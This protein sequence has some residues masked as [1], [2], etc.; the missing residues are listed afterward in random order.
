MTAAI[1]LQTELIRL[2]AVLLQHATFQQL[3]RI[4]W[5]QFYWTGS[6]L[7]ITGHFPTVNVVSF[8]PKGS[9]ENVN[10]RLSPT[11]LVL[12][13]SRLYKSFKTWTR[14][15]GYFRLN[16]ARSFE[17]KTDVIYFKQH[18]AIK[19]ARLTVVIS[20]CGEHMLSLLHLLPLSR[21]V[22]MLKASLWV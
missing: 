5:S 15:A 20:I 17:T 11:L 1:R 19:A 13:F 21:H 8:R 4:R 7:S 10:V 12:G 3:D 14:H 6:S 18:S 22:A 9:G 16:A 2:M